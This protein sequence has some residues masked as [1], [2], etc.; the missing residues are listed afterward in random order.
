MNKYLFSTLLILLG[1]C[2]VTSCGGDEDGPDT[3]GGSSSANSIIYITSSESWWSSQAFN[4]I[5]LS[6]IRTDIPDLALV[7]IDG[8]PSGYKLELVKLSGTDENGFHSYE[9]RADMPAISKTTSSNENTRFEIKYKLEGN[10]YRAGKDQKISRSN[11][12]SMQRFYCPTPDK[13]ILFADWYLTEAEVTING[14]WWSYDT[15]NDKY[16]SSLGYTMITS[17]DGTPPIWVSEILV[18][19]YPDGLGN[20]LSETTMYFDILSG[21]TLPGFYSLMPCKNQLV[22]GR[23]NDD[24]NTASVAFINENV[25][26]CIAVGKSHTGSV[27]NI[28]RY[29]FKKK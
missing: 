18:N 25:M 22:D 26:H 2:C 3:P 1:F 10:G 15:Y 29:T 13:S 14:S 9:L 23:F 6:D 27:S 19:E 5:V 7:D 28:Y 17:T 20:L 12:I 4:G 16:Q 21:Y 11:S 8:L 24:L